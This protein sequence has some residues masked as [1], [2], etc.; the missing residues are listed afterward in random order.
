M[1]I[2]IFHLVA[3]LHICHD[4][5]HGNFSFSPNVITTLVHYNIFIGFPHTE[6]YLLLFM[7]SV[8]VVQLSSEVPEAEK[9]EGCD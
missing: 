6:M 1:S 9:T 7:Y 8:F 2:M 5:C 3:Y 4:G